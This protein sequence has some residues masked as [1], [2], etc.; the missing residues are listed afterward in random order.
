MFDRDNLAQAGNFI[1][2]NSRYSH[3]KVINNKLE[4][5]QHTLISNTN[6]KH[7]RLLV[8]S[9]GMQNNEEN[10][11]F[12]T[13]Q[14]TNSDIIYNNKYKFLELQPNSLDRYQKFLEDGED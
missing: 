10:L 9:N 13:L 14:L 5:Q 4:E 2:L 6:R 8:H 12:K 7:F 11:K 3:F 1:L